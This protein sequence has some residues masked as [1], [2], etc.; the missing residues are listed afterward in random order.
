MVF[1]DHV[2]KGR[3]LRIAIG[4]T[5]L[6]LMMAGG[7]GATRSIRDDATGG[8]CTSFGICISG[9]K[10]YFVNNW[11]TTKT[12][13][14]NIIGGPNLGGN[15]WAYP[16]GTGFSQTCTDADKDRICDTQYTLDSNNIDYL[17]LA[18]NTVGLPKT[19]DINGDGQL[20]L[21]DAI[22]LAKHVGEFIGYEKI[23]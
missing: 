6:V 14:I 2:G 11:N 22:Y 20:T 23:Y 10:S 8:D 13:G 3:A 18:K 5:A 7:A 1:D 15:F 4:T 19:G 9:T 16:N 12:P 21:V 17:P